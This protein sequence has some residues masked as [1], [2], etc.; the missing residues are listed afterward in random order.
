MA[1]GDDCYICVGS[2]LL[3]V[4]SHGYCDTSELDAS[5]AYVIGANG[6]EIAMMIDVKM[7]STAATIVIWCL[8]VALV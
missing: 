3:M 2:S 4:L 1:V 8:S 5:D 6:G 7:V